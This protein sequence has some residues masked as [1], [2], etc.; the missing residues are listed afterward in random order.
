MYWFVHNLSVLILSKPNK[1]DYQTNYPNMWD[2]VFNQN[3]Y[4]ELVETKKPVR[5]CLTGFK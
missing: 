5:S 3:G 4:P 1:H 2:F